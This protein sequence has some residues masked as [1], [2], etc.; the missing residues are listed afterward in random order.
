M[1][2]LIRQIGLYINQSG[3]IQIGATGNSQG[4]DPELDVAVSHSF[5]LLWS[6]IAIVKVSI[7][8]YN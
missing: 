2:K 3:G 5:A 4:L 8:H 6:R 1:V 7:E